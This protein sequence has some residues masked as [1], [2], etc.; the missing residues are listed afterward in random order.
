[1]MS[2]QLFQEIVSEHGVFQFTERDDVT[3]NGRRGPRYEA[4]CEMTTIILD[5]DN[6]FHVTAGFGSAY[7]EDLSQAL[8][9]AYERD[10]DYYEAEIAHI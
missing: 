10:R 7:G 4:Q 3:Q 9:S 2:F 5:L 8:E 6:I 1:M